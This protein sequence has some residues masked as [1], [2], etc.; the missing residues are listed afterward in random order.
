MTL[1]FSSLITRHA[2]R[3]RSTVTWTSVILVSA[4]SATVH[5]EAPLEAR[6]GYIDCGS[7]Q[8]RAR[9]ECVAGSAFCETETLSF[10]RAAGRVIVA[11][12]A[13][14]SER[15]VAD[16]KV[17]VADY[18]A[19]SWACI[20]GREGS[21][22]LVVIMSRA[23]GRCAEC[24]YS[25]LYDL[26]GRLIATDYTFDRSGRARPDQS[27][28]DTMHAVLGGPGRHRFADVYR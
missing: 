16:A 19:Q 21:H 28:R 27:G 7:T 10:S 15:L 5:A 2:L 11:L 3:R 17:R 4:F 22:Y 6:T 23:D 25:R 12:H 13:K 18:V 24:E 1:P 9:A 20:P 8:I 26:T 14:H